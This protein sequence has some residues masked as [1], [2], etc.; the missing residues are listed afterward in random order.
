MKLH[1][2]RKSKRHSSQSGDQRSLTS[3]FR[4][5]WGTTA[6]IIQFLSRSGSQVYC[7]IFLR[8]V[9]TRPHIVWNAQQN[10]EVCLCLLH[11]L[12]EGSLKAAISE[13][14]SADEGRVQRYGY[15][16]ADSTCQ[17]EKGSSSTPSFTLINVKLRKMEGQGYLA[18]ER[19]PILR[20]MSVIQ[21]GK[22]HS[23]FHS[24]NRLAGSVIGNGPCGTYRTGRGALLTPTGKIEPGS[25]SIRFSG[26]SDVIPERIDSKVKGWDIRPYN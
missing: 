17:A 25:S 20:N 15:G 11:Y 4:M 5:E 3:S 23:K 24:S 21:T 13:S 12:D 14:S 10:T 16:K 7:I 8:K 6:G 22:D 2:M 9:E 19:R 26:R 18:E 1:N